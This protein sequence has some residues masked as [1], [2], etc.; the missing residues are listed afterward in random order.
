MVYDRQ[1][2]AVLL[3]RLPM[4]T[5][6]Q[7]LA[8][9]D[10][11]RER[12]AGL[13]AA[14]YPDRML[15]P[16]RRIPIRRLNALLRVAAPD[17]ISAA[18]YTSVRDGDPWLY[19]KTA[20]PPPVLRSLLNAW[21]YDLARKDI[22][23]PLVVPTIK[24][25]DAA[26]LEWRPEKVDLLECTTSDGGT[27]VPKAR[28]YTLLPDAIAWQI[29]QHS[30]RR[31]YTHEGGQLRFRQVAANPSADGAELVSWPP[32]TY[33]TKGKNPSS[34]LY[35]AYLRIALRTVPFDPRPR[36]HVNVGVRRWTT[37]AVRPKGRN[38]ASVYLLSANPFAAGASVPDKFAVARVQW[39][40]KID[41]LS[42]VNSGPEQMLSRLN[43]I[44][45]LPDAAELGRQSDL[46]L[47][48][49]DGVTAAVVHHTTMR[50]SHEV[51]TG[52]MP[53]ERRRLLAWVEGVV[54]PQFELAGPLH[55]VPGIKRAGNT[56]TKLTSIPRSNSAKLPEADYEAKLAQARV[57]RR[58]ETA[59]NARL[60][61]QRL[62][63]V[64]GAQGL[65]VALL[66]QPSRT[67]RNLLLDTVEEL[68]DLP[69]R[70]AADA[71]TWTWN[72][73]GFTLTVR[74][75]LLSDLG[76]PL[77]GGGTPR[78]G[79]QHDAAVTARRSGVAAALTAWGREQGGAADAAL[80]VLDGRDA[81]WRRTTD[82]KFAIRLGCADAGAVSQFISPEKD[83]EDATVGH[84]AE[85]AWLD[86]FR[87]VGMRFVPEARGL[88]IPD[89]LNQ[90]AFWI[91]KRRKD[92]TNTRKLFIPVAV[93]IRPGNP[94][95][96][97]RAKGMTGWV[98]YPQLLKHLAGYHDLDMPRTEQEQTVAV[99]AFV[100]STLSALR[101]DETLVV[102][103]AQ[104]IRNRLPSLQNTHLEA[105]R[106]QFAD[107]VSQPV[108][109]FGERMRLVRVSGNDRMETPQ[110]WAAQ[111]DSTG[112]SAG[113]WYDAQHLD[114]ENTRVFYSTVE[115]PVTHNKIGVELAK[116]TPHHTK[117][118]PKPDASDEQ[119]VKERDHF[120]PGSAAWNPELVQF[121]VVAKPDDET[122]LLWAA[123]LHQQ[124]S[125]SDDYTSALGVPLILHLAT[126]TTRYA[127]P[128]E[129]DEAEDGPQAPEDADVAAEA[130]DEDDLGLEL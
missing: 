5:T 8:F 58:A 78:K 57:T 63:E 102:V 95:V 115:K 89:G 76:G 88:D 70:T 33:Q 21:L 52:I 14:N 79:A 97:G 100:R 110:A 86:L 15:S 47:P 66:D 96:M 105:E 77:G 75:R 34:W 28:L 81:F 37:N 124:R 64:T 2:P 11:W 129:D 122:S 3:P 9:P 46:W 107:G 74:A 109:T 7:T 130:D 61:R 39:N 128:T 98:P 30:A 69:P 48:E 17:L 99:A 113:L 42:W 123:F 36:L 50:G 87:Q 60:R 32:L 118:E 120:N 4:T 54:A 43:I 59:A 27:A 25:L 62:A 93:L 101:P 121:T 119:E 19:A 65:T 35:S 80:V 45:E 114:L 23:R 112:I 73:D 106:I 111:P 55:K 103:D 56:F 1:Q 82:P 67:M 29:A 127:L 26:E 6:F 16:T 20:C 116:L 53:A 91:V 126:L 12:I 40:P 22:A 68:L 92:D 85:A 72:V 38:A 31:P 108:A 18:T 90:I 71:D 94:C 84:R 24:A 104:N 51:G 44:A 13:H 125:C 117:T 83:A 41:A 10:E 49:R